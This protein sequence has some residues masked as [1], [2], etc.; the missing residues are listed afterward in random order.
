MITTG[1]VFEQ[2]RR[3]MPAKHNL[4]VKWLCHE[5][6]DMGIHAFKDVRES[7]ACVNRQAAKSQFG[8]GS[9]L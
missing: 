2:A 8:H 5:I 7:G 1:W 9:V 6:I 4:V 3:V